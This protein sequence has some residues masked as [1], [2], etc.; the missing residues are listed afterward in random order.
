MK[1]KTYKAE[2]MQEALSQIK[3]E[4]GPEAVILKTK[5]GSRRVLGRNRDFVEVTAALDES[6]YAK[7]QPITSKEPPRQETRMEPAAPKTYDWRG[8]LPVVEE[9]SVSAPGKTTPAKAPKEQ[10]PEPAM[11]DWIRT[12]LKQVRESVEMPTRELQILRGEIKDMLAAVNSSRAEQQ[13]ITQAIPIPA[14]APLPVHLEGLNDILLSIDMDPGLA[15]QALT[16]LSEALPPSQ[17]S[18]PLKVGPWLERWLSRRIR[19]LP[20]MRRR[21]GKPAVCMLAGPTGVGKTTTIAKL[22][23][24]AQF[25]SGLK[26]AILSADGHRMGADEHL[27]VFGQSTGIPVRTVFDGAD[28][29]D[30]LRSFAHCDYIL[31]D[32]AGR[33]H[34][35]PEAWEEL[36]ALVLAV[37]PDEIHLTLS[38]TTRL[39]ELQRMADQYQT[40]GA[41][42]L[43]FTKVDECLGLGCIPSLSSSVLPVSFI[44]NGQS[45][46]QDICAATAQNAASLVLQG[47]FAMVEAN[48]RMVA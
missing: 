15:R 45:I 27:K 25:E 12:E 26:V 41:S 40:L 32:T 13:A 6:L 30:A 39:K 42:S 48:A 18:D 35:K 24:R 31:V 19:V 36:R 21:Q 23:A 8:R 34:R 16:Q 2:T 37:Q 29:R 10:T 17:T 20:G 46:P 14:A 5:K 9:D 1:M 43:I 44:C 47:L 22:A 3:D 33:N 4:L 7:P 38:C 28:A 11:M